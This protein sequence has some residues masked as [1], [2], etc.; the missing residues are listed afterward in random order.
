MVQVDLSSY[1]KGGYHPGGTAGRRVAWY[2]VNALFFLNPLNPLSGLKVRLLRAFG[3]RVGRGVVI[4]PGV[5]VKYPW[6]L[7][8]GSHVWI[9]EGVWIDN[10]AP[11]T[12]GNHVCLSQGA[13]LLCGSHDYTRPTFDLRTAPIVL[14][15][16]CWI[17]ARATVCPGVTAGSHSVLAVAS[18]ATRPL[19]PH[20]VYQGNPAVAKRKRRPS[21]TPGTA[22]PASRNAS[23]A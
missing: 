2:F 9:G 18:V 16:G 14:E 13:M 19:L 7:T 10:L 21:E 20:T 17:G 23:P 6:R 22:L 11:V 5:N 15:E 8:V 4:K 3:A 1:D 12:L